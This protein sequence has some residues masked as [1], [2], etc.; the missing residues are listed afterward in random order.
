MI[1]LLIMMI[2]ALTL[3]QELK[4]GMTKKEV[5]AI[6]GEPVRRTETSNIHG[7]V[8]KVNQTETWL[9]YFKYQRGTGE[10]Y[11]ENAYDWRLVDW[12]IRK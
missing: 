11:P 12:V 9:I 2:P 3:G 5:I 7:L 6:L 10:Y 8:F 1:L 4:Y